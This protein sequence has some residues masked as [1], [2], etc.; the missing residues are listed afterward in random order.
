M[1]ESHYLPSWQMDNLR[2]MLR[3]LPEST[4]VLRLNC[5]ISNYPNFFPGGRG[6]KDRSFPKSP[7]MLIGHNFD[8]DIGFRN[9]VA[10]GA[11]DYLRMKTWINLKESFL[12]AAVLDEKDCFFTN[13]YLGAIVHPEPKTGEKRKTTNTGT[14]KCT[15]QYHDACVK[16]LKT[17]VEIARPKVIALLGGKVPSAFGEAF[18]AY[19]AHCGSNIAET[20]S[21]QPLGGHR[22]QL[23]PDLNVQVVCLVHPAN[24]RSTESHRAQ[25]LLLRSAVLA[26]RED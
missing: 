24:P 17:Q 13:F 12:P 2:E 1:S 11:E 16:A 26:A 9:S 18:L 25:G 15:D 3:L 21:K 14:F 22:L 23:L 19:R 10:R 6:Y 4:G 20:Q 8:T 5:E 7:V